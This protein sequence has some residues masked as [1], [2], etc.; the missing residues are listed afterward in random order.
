MSKPKVAFY[1]FSGCSGCLLTIL[2]C[3][4][5]ILDIFNAGQVVSF[6]MASRGNVEKEQD[7]AFVDGSVTTREQAEFIED[8]RSRTKTLVALGVCACYGGVQAMETGRGSFARRYRAVYGP[9]PPSI[10]EAFESKPLDALVKVDYY[11]PG[12]P[13]DGKQ[14]L[15]AYARLV[16]GL[17]PELTKVPVCTECK[18]RENE[19]LLLKDQ[20]CLGPVTAGGCNARCPTNLT[21]CI[22]CYGPADERNLVSE[23][24]LL[25]SRK[26]NLEMIERKLRLFG[27]ARFGE[28]F[29]KV[30][31]KI[32]AGRP[33]RK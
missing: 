26:F 25:K 22:G 31:P 8:I 20:L 3:E 12:C 23:V 15:H 29:R 7:L 30:L 17:P 27:G 5:S 21:G 4:D 6:L 16:R 1:N 18:W 10:V 13:I 11:I 14:F 9:H 2:N 33:G 24:D 28:A 32:H 19:C